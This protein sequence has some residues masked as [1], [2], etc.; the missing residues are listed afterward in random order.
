MI[1]RFNKEELNDKLENTVVY[2][3]EKVW[4][5][6]QKILKTGQYLHQIPIEKLEV[7]IRTPQATIFYGFLKYNKWKIDIM[8]VSKMSFT[9]SS[10]PRWNNVAHRTQ[11]W[12]VPVRNIEVR[13]KCPQWTKAGKVQGWQMLS[14]GIRWCRLL[15]SVP[16]SQA[17][18]N[19]H[20]FLWMFS[21]APNINFRSSI[22]YF[23]RSL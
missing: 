3:A 20:N 13:I 19:L 22:Y 1:W 2:K 21:H 23:Q 12:V 11:G 9:S 14:Q 10:I 18:W 5:Y 15:T 16:Y 4:K 6:E 7:D 17:S 8:S